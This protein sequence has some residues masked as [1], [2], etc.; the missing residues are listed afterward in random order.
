MVALR[1]VL[2][3]IFAAV[4][5]GWPGITLMAVVWLWGAYALVDGIFTS[6]LALRAVEDEEP[7]AALMVRGLCGIVA[8]M[9]AFNWATITALMLAYVVAVWAI[10][11]GLSE[12][13]TAVR[14]RR[15]LTGEWLLAAAGALSVA[16]GVL[17]IA[18]PE[19]GLL[20]WVWLIGAYALLAGI[21]L[22]AL[23]M[24]LRSIGRGAR[25][26]FGAPAKAA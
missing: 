16:L 20:A 13:A 18:N 12:V 3:I 23:G 19:A 21:V 2:A 15:E 4:A 11:A 10:L 17:L 24:R 22:V 8:G 26:H 6:L 14:L 25:P 1:G 5:F 9:V 7:W